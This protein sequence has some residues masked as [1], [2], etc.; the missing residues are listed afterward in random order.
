[1]IR[2]KARVFATIVGSSERTTKFDSRVWLERFKQKNGL[3]GASLPERC[4][5][6]DFGIGQTLNTGTGVRT[7][8]GISSISPA[9]QH[10]GLSNYEMVKNESASSFKSGDPTFQWILSKNDNS[11]RN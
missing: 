3:L 9:E 4:E 8:Y 7:P 6:K 11:P 1:M 5:A 2:D 10:S